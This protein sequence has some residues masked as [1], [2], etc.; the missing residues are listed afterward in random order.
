MESKFNGES[1]RIFNKTE[2]MAPA[3]ISEIKSV[4]DSVGRPWCLFGTDDDWAIRPGSAKLHA[5]GPTLVVSIRLKWAEEQDFVAPEGE[6]PIVG[7]F[8]IPELSAFSIT[9]PRLA[10]YVFP[11]SATPDTI[12]VT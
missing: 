11:L 6:I 1:E 3:D 4:I 5:D 8:R 7:V 9:H 12:N 10:Y 2:F